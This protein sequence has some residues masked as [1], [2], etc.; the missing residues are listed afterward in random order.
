MSFSEIS[1]WV[2]G[3]AAFL[4]ACGILWKFVSVLSKLVTFTEQHAPV[5]VTIA[6]QFKKNGG[7]SLK[8]QIDR[9]EDMSKDAKTKAQEAHVE[10]KGARESVIRIEENVR[11][12]LR[13]VVPTTTT[14]PPPH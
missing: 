11:T 13:T 4:I 3:A 9:I 6:E 5:L 2:V 7:N 14:S 1:A 10:A 12:I 8:D